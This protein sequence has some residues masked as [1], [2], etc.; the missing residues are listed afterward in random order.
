[1]AIDWQQP[2]LAE[3]LRCYRSRQFFLAHE[4]WEDVWRACEGNERLF[5]QALIQV[6][7]AMHHFSQG[8]RAGAA[9]LLRRSLGRLELF[10]ADFAGVEVG[11]LRESMRAWLR[12]LDDVPSGSDAVEMPAPTIR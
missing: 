9:S 5:L 12:L 8:N 11:R 3:G 4:H 10:P 2:E 1:M 6:A 7:V